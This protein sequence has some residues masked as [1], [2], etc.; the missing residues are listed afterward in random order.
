MGILSRKQALEIARGLVDTS[1]ADE[2]EV[3]IESQADRFV[4]FAA[5]GP[6]QSADRERH[7]VSI[8]VRIDSGEGKR[9][10]AATCDGVDTALTA[11]AL[12]RAVELARHAPPNPDLIP[13]GGPVDVEDRR[14]D[15][16][17]L[18]HGFEPKADWVRTAVEACEREDLLPAGLT[19]TGG[20]ARAVVNSAGRQVYAAQS[21]ASFAL[22]ASTPDLVGGAG[23]ADQIAA[24][25]A[26]LDPDEVIRRAVLKADR[27]R[28]AEAIDAGE[29]T[30]VLEPAAVSAM[31]LFAGYKGFGC[32]DVEEQS[33]FLC[34]RLG[35][36][37]LSEGLTIVDD[38]SNDFY[39]GIPFDYE[40]SPKV[41][42]DLIDRGLVKGMVT[43]HAWSRKLGVPNT[44]HGRMQP[45][46]GGPTT[47][48]LCVAAGDQSLDELIAGVERGLLVTQFHY[49]NLINPRE[50]TL[51]GM[52]R[53]GTFLIENGKV[54]RP[55]K[56]LRFTMSMTKAWSQIT[57]VGNELHVAGALFDGEV[58][59][60]ALRIDGFRFTS[61]T[62]F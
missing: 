61:T 27:S 45:S 54:T 24:T 20:Y 58:V 60:P 2:T 50:L 22:T 17:T 31:L 57:G 3:V 47:S 56:N 28:G 11:G 23:F 4:R 9:E 37:C 46:P 55:V 32:Q 15:E 53:N 62:A 48:N 12:E 10:G 33:S 44:G 39:P 5:T 13:L 25:V 21:R 49:T 7:F 16:A 36:R 59:T 1:T 29:Y 40:G 8:R 43:D 18:E 26:E 19:Q 52:T 34:G 51:T 38:A 35:E 6:T 41:R 42:V 30:V 14:P